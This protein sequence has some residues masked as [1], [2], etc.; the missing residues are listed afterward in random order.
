MAIDYDSLYA[1]SR[2][3]EIQPTAKPSA[4]GLPPLDLAEAT[5]VLLAKAVNQA[6]ISDDPKVI[7]PVLDALMKRGHA[8]SEKDRVHDIRVILG[9]MCEDCREKLKEMAF[10]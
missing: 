5:P 10:E 8:E 4:E 7:I 2:P 9:V 1:S 6:R 3:K